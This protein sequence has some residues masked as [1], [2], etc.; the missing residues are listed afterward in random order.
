MISLPDS[1]GPTTFLQN[2]KYTG[3][4]I[5]GTLGGCHTGFQPSLIITLKEVLPPVPPT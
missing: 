2:A 5:W 3:S 4:M 1:E